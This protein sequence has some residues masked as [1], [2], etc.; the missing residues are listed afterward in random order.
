MTQQQLADAVGLSLQSVRQWERATGF[1][2][3]AK[4]VEIARALGVTPA[5]LVPGP[6]EPST[7]PASVREMP[8]APLVPRLQALEA[9]LASIMSEVRSLRQEAAERLLQPGSRVS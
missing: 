2:H 7:W 6:H 4:L 5:E 9:Q 8:A 3:M 1:P